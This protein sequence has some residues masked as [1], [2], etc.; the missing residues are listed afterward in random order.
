MHEATQRRYTL[1]Q[2]KRERNLQRATELLTSCKCE[3][4]LVSYRNQ[5]GHGTMIDGNPCP[6][7]AVWARHRE[8]DHEAKAL[9]DR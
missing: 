3:F 1:A 8:E 7:I 9:V 5:H 6:A 4:P 2:K